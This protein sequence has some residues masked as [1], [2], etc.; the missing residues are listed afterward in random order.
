MKR[1]F[2]QAAKYE[3]SQG[4]AH[5]TFLHALRADLREKLYK[6]G[7]GRG[8]A[9]DQDMILDYLMEKRVELSKLLGTEESAVPTKESQVCRVSLHDD[10]GRPFCRE[11][12]AT[13][14]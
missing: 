8:G 2:V 11:C 4:L 13:R 3:D 14:S 1:I 12:D 7:V 6:D 10:Y 5:D 9:W